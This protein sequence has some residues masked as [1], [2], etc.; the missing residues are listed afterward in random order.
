MQVVCGI[1]HYYNFYR[2][3]YPPLCC[4]RKGVFTNKQ[5]RLG[6]SISIKMASQPCGG[7]IANTVRVFTADS[8]Q[9]GIRSNS[10]HYIKD[11]LQNTLLLKLWTPQRY[12]GEL[13]K[14]FKVNMDEGVALIS[15]SPNKNL[16]HHSRL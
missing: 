14:W 4:E 6:C 1:T 8:T 11:P 10:C 5:Y 2:Q 12:I 7:T 9:S 13:T 15:K 3:L 16:V